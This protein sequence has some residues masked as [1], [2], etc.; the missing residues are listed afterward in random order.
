[1][2]VFVALG[3]RCAIARR[4][5]KMQKLDSAVGITIRLAR[6]AAGLSRATPARACGISLRHMIA[7]ERG[8]NFTV[9]MLLA[10]VRELPALRV[11][12]VAAALLG[13]FADRPSPA[14]DPRPKR[15]RPRPGK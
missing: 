5:R 11:P 14:S 1:M 6:K 3:P 13:A 10:I 12:D 7:I 9:A 2:C 8:S 4:I 15:R